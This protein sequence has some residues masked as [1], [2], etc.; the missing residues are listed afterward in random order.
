MAR[1]EAVPMSSLLPIVLAADNFPACGSYPTH[2][3]GTGEL[4]VPFH[5]APSD[6]A[7]ALPPIG[8]LRPEVLKALEGDAAY[9]SVRGGDSGIVCVTF[10]PNVLAGGREAMDKAIAETAA[11]WRA[12]GLF[13]PALDGWRDELYAIYASPTSAAFSTPPRGGWRNA[14]FACERAAC[15]VWG[16]ATFGVHM[17]AYEGEGEGMQIWVPRRSPTKATWPSMLDNVSLT[18]RAALTVDGRR[19]D[20]RRHDAARHDDQGV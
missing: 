12:A 13:K 15:A 17:T 20:H 11:R 19:R 3:P 8:L 14:A 4:Y 2:H 5:V 16:F 6:H 7:A 1:P 10:S 9:E 18:L